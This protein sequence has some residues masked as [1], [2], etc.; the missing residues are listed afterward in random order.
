LITK[1]LISTLQYYQPRSAHTEMGP[2][3]TA[4]KI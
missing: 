2:E 1:I 4:L 3:P